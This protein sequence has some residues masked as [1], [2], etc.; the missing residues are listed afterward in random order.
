MRDFRINLIFEGSSEIMRLYIAREA[1]DHHFRTAFDIV[2]PHA[3]GK[4]RWAA[5][6]RSAR[7][8][9]FWYPSMWIG[10]GRSYHEFGRLS[11]HLRFVER[12]TR[13]LGRSVFHAMVRLGPKLEKRQMV[14]FRLVDVG[15]ELFAMAAS[16][17]R[18]KMLAA[19]GDANAI[20]IADLF[21]REARLRI[22]DSFRNLFGKNDGALYKVS[23]KVL[24][25]EYSWMELGIVTGKETVLA[26]SPIEPAR[27]REPVGV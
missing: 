11:D 7:F 22:A 1:V 8:Y 10:G 6:L 5:F 26:A 17:S 15:A 25:G 9:P 18:A 12:T 24:A 19:A 14:L 27:R 4:Q 16:C 2:N 21:C 20:D 23:Q 3:T 13:K